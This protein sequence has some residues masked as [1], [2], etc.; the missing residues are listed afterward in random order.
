MTIR[1]Y[2]EKDREAV[3]FVC[4]NS[5]GPC[6]DDEAG[7]HFLLTTYCDYYIEREPG[8]CFVCVD[9]ADHAVG[10]VFCAADFDRFWN[11]FLTDFLPRIP[12]NDVGRR[13]AASV[14]DLQNKHKKQYPAHL[15]IDLLPEAQRRGQGRALMNALL[16]GLKADHVPGLML[17]V[18]KDNAGAI[19]FYEKLG[20]T[21]IDETENFYAYGIFL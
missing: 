21:R 7:Q 12:E 13:Y 18:W 20:F 17:S 3:R 4:L 9:D 8:T 16:A 15:H 1:A 19:R 10:Y 6:E 14:Y 5:D 11:A 2:E